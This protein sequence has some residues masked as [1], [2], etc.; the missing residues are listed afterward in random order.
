MRS[1]VAGVDPH[2][3]VEEPE[4]LVHAL[5]LVHEKADVAVERPRLGPHALHA[6]VQTDP[7]PRLHGAARTSPR[8]PHRPKTRTIA[9][10]NRPRI[11][12][13]EVTRI[14]TLC[15][16][17]NWRHDSHAG[18]HAGSHDPD[19]GSIAQIRQVLIRAV[20]RHCP[21]AWPLTGKIWC[22]WPWSGSWNGPAVRD[23]P[24]WSVIPLESRVHGGH[25]RDSPV[26]PAAAPGRAAAGGR[27]ERR[28]GRRRARSSWTASGAPGPAPRR[29]HPPPGGLPDGEVATALGWTEKQAENLV[30]RG[31]ADLRAC[32]EGGDT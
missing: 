32:L 12:P 17:R 29:G 23:L 4:R 3:L 10:K 20:E 26:S 16:P 14:G 27:A 1:R 22:R 5:P 6:C 13:R 7:G 15:L 18:G 9:G 31:L 8:S 19:P 24:P 21:P 25:R 28:L 2:A 11:A 30:Y